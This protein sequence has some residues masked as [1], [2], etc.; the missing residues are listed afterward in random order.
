MGTDQFGPTERTYWV[1]GDV[2]VLQKT[3]AGKI[4]K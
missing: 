1:S 2:A 4:N 3:S